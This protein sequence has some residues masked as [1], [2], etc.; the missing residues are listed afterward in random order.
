MQSSVVILASSRKPG[1]VCLAGKRLHGAQHGAWVRPV[2]EETGHGWSAGTL[3][4]RAGRIPSVGD[5]FD[6]PLA[7]AQPW[8]HQTENWQVGQG[9]WACT[10]HFTSRELLAFADDN[11]TL[12]KNGW[13]STA[14]INDRVPASTSVHDGAGSLRLIRPIGLTFLAAMEFGRRKLRAR[15]YYRGTLYRLCVTDLMAASR[16]SGRLAAG[17]NGAVEALLCISLGQP[18]SDYCYKLIAGVIELS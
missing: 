9:A 7:A 13:C 10:G 14:G 6:I 1:G 15:F 16:W 11:T 3:A 8:E 2:W 18:M 4:T 12:W 5:I 17:H